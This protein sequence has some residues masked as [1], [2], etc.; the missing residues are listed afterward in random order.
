LCIDIRDPIKLSP[1]SF[2]TDKYL[3]VD[4]HGGV[5]QVTPELWAEAMTVYRPDVAVTMA[6]TVTDLEAKTKRIKRSVDRTLR[7]LDEN[8]KKSKELELPVF[9]PVMGH[10]DENERMRSAIATAERDVQ[11]TPILF[12]LNRS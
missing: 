8:V 5:R 9:A 4:T 12:D 1:V 3:S 6:D 2:N 11:G 10:T 7:W